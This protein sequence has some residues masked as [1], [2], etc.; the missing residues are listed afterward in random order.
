MRAPATPMA[1]G[2][3]VRIRPSGRPPRG[4]IWDGER[5]HSDRTTGLNC[6]PGCSARPRPETVSAV[7]RDVDRWPE[8]DAGVA[9]SHLDG[10]FATGTTGLMVL[11]DRSALRFR[12]AWVDEGRG[13][14]DEAEVP[15]AGALVR[16]RHALEPLAA[17][18]TRITYRA[19]V[20]G[21]AADV[22]GVMARLDRRV[23]REQQPGRQAG[24]LRPTRAGRHLPLEQPQRMTIAGSPDEIAGAWRRT[25]AWMV[26][27]EALQQ[28]VP[29][30]RPAGGSTGP[31]T[32]GVWE[33]R[34]HS[35]TCPVKVPRWDAS[36]AAWLERLECL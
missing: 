4:Y 12:L 2:R 11:P 18:G 1:R 36:W 13:F 3:S 25:P 17:G 26:M 32:S 16:V 23:A 29:S 30:H 35:R 22:A 6:R 9:R 8:W 20:E 33:A 27:H 7:L 24:P 31:P 34:R 5:L 10:P 28:L 15:G 14:E 19:T 21:P